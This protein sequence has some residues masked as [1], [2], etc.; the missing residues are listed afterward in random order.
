MTYVIFRNTFSWRIPTGNFE[1]EGLRRL[2]NF[3]ATNGMSSEQTFERVFA[4]NQS[5]N[6]H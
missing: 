3:M 2:R 1:V 4:R 6:K 5:V